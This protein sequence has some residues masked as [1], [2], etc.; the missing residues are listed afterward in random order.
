M[1]PEATDQGEQRQVGQRAY[2]MTPALFSET[3]HLQRAGAGAPLKGILGDD[4]AVGDLQRDMYL[5]QR[6]PA[7]ITDDHRLSA[8]AEA[9]LCEADQ[10]DDQPPQTHGE[11][12]GGN[13]AADAAQPQGDE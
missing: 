8:D 7:R 1:R 2:A 5:I 9:G 3:A 12:D 13:G 6:E 4:Q 10:P 11:A